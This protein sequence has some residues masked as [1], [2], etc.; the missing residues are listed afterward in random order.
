MQG[1]QTTQLKPG[2]LVYCA[3]EKR[4]VVS[5]FPSTKNYRGYLVLDNGATVWP[6]DVRR[7]S[8]LISFLRGKKN[9]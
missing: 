2:D 4:T 7:A 9:G 8:K 1:N 5:S 6:E 3:G